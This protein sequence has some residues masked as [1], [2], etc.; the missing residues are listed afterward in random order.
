MHHAATRLPA[1]LRARKLL[2]SQRARLSGCG[3]AGRAAD[4][5]LAGRGGA[6][7][8]VVGSGRAAHLQS[9]HV[10]AHP[11]LLLLVSHLGAHHDVVQLGALQAGRRGV[12]EGGRHGGERGSREDQRAWP[13]C[14][15][16]LRQRVLNAVQEG[17]SHSN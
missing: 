8:A 11:L 15:Q 4:L 5:G 6:A 12:R 1:E 14:W 2:A 9:G 7:V 16:G 10:V 3:P 13:K 17:L